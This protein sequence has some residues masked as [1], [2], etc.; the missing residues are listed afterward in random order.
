MRFLVDNA[1]SPFL[2]H[3]LREAGHDAVHVREYGLQDA[4]DRTILDRAAL[5]DR[6]LLSADTDFSAILSQ[7]GA[8]KPSV[9]LFRRKFGRRPQAQLALLL[10]N[11]PSIQDALEKGS[12]VV[13]ED[14]RIRVRNLPI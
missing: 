2:A 5:E 8:D 10:R 1:L 14:N 12:V 13:I 7:R 6:V 11:L 4:D 3:G 9:V